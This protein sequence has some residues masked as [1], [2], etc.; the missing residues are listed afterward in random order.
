MHAKLSPA[1][2]RGGSFCALAWGPAHPRRTSPILLGRA[3]IGTARPASLSR[4]RTPVAHREGGRFHP[5]RNLPDRLSRNREQHH[6]FSLGSGL[7]SSDRVN[8]AE[9]PATLRPVI[10]VTQIAFAHRAKRMLL[11]RP[12]RP[13]ESPCCFDLSAGFGICVSSRFTLDNPA[14]WKLYRGSC[15]RFRRHHS[16]PRHHAATTANTTI[17]NVIIAAFTWRLPRGIMRPDRRS[18]TRPASPGRHLAPA[19][20]AGHR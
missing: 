8:K 9:L 13:A 2:R 10:A 20:A 11:G 7:R 16:Y 18:A 17:T 6:I 19:A 3:G 1:L 15:R 5:K 4:A 14:C 12:D